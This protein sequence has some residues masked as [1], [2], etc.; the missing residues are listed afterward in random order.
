MTGAWAANNIQ[1]KTHK[2]YSIRDQGRRVGVVL[3]KQCYN[4]PILYTLNKMK[5]HRTYVVSYI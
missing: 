4:T 5:K 1:H 2:T 3:Q